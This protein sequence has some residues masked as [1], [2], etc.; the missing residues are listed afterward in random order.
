VLAVARHRLLGGLGRQV[1]AAEEL[2]GVELPHRALR[3]DLRVER[4]VRVRGVVAL[5]VPP[6]AVADEVHDDVA[7]ERFAEGERQP[8]HADGVFGLIAVHVED[9]RLDHA[10]D[11]GRV[12][13]GPRVLRARREPDLVV[14][15][16]VDRPA[17]AVAAELRQVERLGDD[18]LA[19]ERGIAVEEDRED[20]A[21][22]V[23]ACAILLRAHGTLDDRIDRLEVAGVGRQRHREPGAGRGDV[24]ARRAQV[25]LDVARAVRGLGVELP[26][27]LAED[28]RV[29]LPHDVRQDV[30]APAVGHP[31]DRFADPG[32]GRVVE[33][34]IEHRH[35]GLAALEREALLADVGRVQELL[36]RLGGAEL[37]EDA[38]LLG[39]GQRGRVARG[40]HPF[41]EPAADRQL[42]D[43]H[44]L[45]ADVTAVR[46]AEDV[47][48]LAQ[49]TRLAASGEGARGEALVEVPHGK[50][51]ERQLEL[52]LVERGRAERIEVRREVAAHAEGA[53][54]LDDARLLL[55]V[56]D[57]LGG[58]DTRGRLLLPHGLLGDAELLEDLVVEPLAA[59]EQ[60][61]DRREERARRR[62]LDDPVVVRRGD[63]HHP[64]EAD[65]GDR[66]LG[67]AGVLRRVADRAQ[68][69]DDALP[70]HE[71][72]H[73]HRRPD[74]P[75][76]RDR[77][78]RPREIVGGQGTGARLVDEGVVGAEE[79][80]EV[81]RARVLHVRHEQH[82][83]AL[84]LGVHRDA[85]ADRAA[86]DAVGDAVPL[87]V[88]RV[89][90]GVRLERLH[91]GPADEM[92]ERHLRAVA[93]GLV[94]VDRAP[95]LLEVTHRDGADRRRRRNLERGVHVLRDRRLDPLQGDGVR[96]DRGGRRRGCLL[97]LAGGG[98]RLHGDGLRGR[99]PL[100]ELA[101]CLADRLG[102]G[103]IAA[104]ELVHVPDVLSESAHRA[105]YPTVSWGER[106][107]VRSPSS[108]SAFRPVEGARSAGR[109]R[110]WG[111][112]RPSSSAG[113][114]TRRGRARPR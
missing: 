29:R 38:R 96:R 84:L 74:R 58:E 48:D 91:D 107:S 109:G 24:H 88:G 9:R 66:L 94:L 69:D 72:R 63:R 12:R 2:L 102:V 42:L 4:G 47:E 44:E 28:R 80:G 82:A 81:E 52:V 68:A 108:S 18:P 95:V 77:H 106:P 10:R 70:R 51:V 35:E 62:A 23:V 54:E 79:A 37:L 50:A 1:A 16:D 46:V 3:L 8:H 64:R 85:E 87:H 90:R 31:D 13:G 14:D 99:V 40:L 19:C 65:A 92:G 105:G 103:Q 41:L 6:A 104:V 71:A 97:R 17:G 33:D 49:R 27:E 78:G 43:V 7:A 20:G 101:P 34:R 32:V 83:L 26:L 25:V 21:V 53:H 15:D 22:L 93:R 36:E 110:R 61:L 39:R 114:G 86:G 11:V 100:E 59:E 73:R 45:D 75:R 89:H 57:L 56:G 5:V 30:E 112:T 98:R 60:L 67:H 76:V 55:V 113:P 111:R